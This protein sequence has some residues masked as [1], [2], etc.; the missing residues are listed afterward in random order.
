MPLGSASDISIRCLFTDTKTGLTFLSRTGECTI[1]SSDG[2]ELAKPTAL[3]GLE[4]KYIK[5]DEEGL[6][7]GAYIKGFKI[8][9]PTVSLSD[10]NS[11][12]CYADFR[13]YD[14]DGND[15]DAEVLTANSAIKTI[16]EN[17]AV[18]GDFTNWN[19]YIQNS[20]N[21]KEVYVLVHNVLT[22]NNSTDDLTDKAI[23]YDLIA[24]YP[25][26]YDTSASSNSSS[27]QSVRRRAD[28]LSDNMAITLETSKITG[29]VTATKT[30]VV[31]GVESV[32]AD[33]DLNA[34]VEYYTI[35]GIRV[36][37]TP[38]P[39][40]YIRRQGNTVSKVAIR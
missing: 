15:Y 5:E 17:L 4:T 36:V 25:F 40:I 26:L 33:Q 9:I 35:S 28:S 23:N 2:V 6:V 24:S 34:P 37:G 12:S 30:N 14:A 16:W 1:T 27:S 10:D 20:D 18:C 21:E 11:L 38:A 13:F 39:G 29:S 22:L 3:S 8:N 7:Y 32:A 19:E 31:S